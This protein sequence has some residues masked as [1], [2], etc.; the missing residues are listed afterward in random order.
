MNDKQQIE[1]IAQDIASN[2]P[3]MVDNACGGKPCYVCLAERLVKDNYRKLPENAVVLTREEYEKLKDL[4]ESYNH[5]EKTKDEL[6]SERN[7]LALQL[8]QARK[9]TAKELFQAIEKSKYVEKFNGLSGAVKM[10]SL[11]NLK[12]IMKDKFGV[13]I[14]E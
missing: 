4:D 11:S 2:C 7:K 14:K 12:K 9:E 1:E 13:E 5:L 6:L 3:D 10:I 8:A